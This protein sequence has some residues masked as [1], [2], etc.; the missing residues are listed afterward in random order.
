MNESWERALALY[1]SL[2]GE[3]WRYIAAFRGLVAVLAESKEAAGLTAVTSHA[4]LI[5][6]PYTTYPDWFDGRHVELHPLSDGNV[7]VS[8]HPAR[9]DTQSSE[10]WTLSLSDAEGKARSLIAEL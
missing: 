1:D 2:L 8:R 10:T 5:V 6:S 3:N 9:F 4:T 7:R